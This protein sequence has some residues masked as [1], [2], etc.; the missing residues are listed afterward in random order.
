MKST[1]E[2]S[3]QGKSQQL[4]ATR[5]RRTT[6]TTP[7]QQ[8]ETRSLVDRKKADWRSTT[9]THQIKRHGDERTDGDGWFLVSLQKLMGWEFQS[10]SVRGIITW[11][12]SRKKVFQKLR[13]LW[14][15]SSLMWGSYS[16]E[17]AIV[18]RDCILEYQKK[19]KWKE[20]RKYMSNHFLW[21]QI[22][23]TWCIY[24]FT[25]TSWQAV[26]DSCSGF[27]NNPGWNVNMTAW[28]FVTCLMFHWV[29]TGFCRT[30]TTKSAMF[31]KIAKLEYVKAFVHSNQVSARL[32]DLNTQSGY[33]WNYPI[34][35]N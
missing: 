30:C 21:K 6:T 32:H 19:I 35:M 27:P 14:R 12:L 4:D 22:C 5:R 8:D 34:S 31:A 26:L 20:K 17:E 29:Q 16:R 33:K 7:L 2:T 10:A 1:S 3:W 15:C 13:E 11:H 9:T 23:C 25:S 28:L 24:S 18:V